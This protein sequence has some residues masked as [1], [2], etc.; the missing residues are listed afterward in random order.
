MNNCG[1]CINSDNCIKCVRLQLSNVNDKNEKYKKILHDIM[2]DID[3]ND[4]TTN[5]Y[6]SVL[7]EKNKNGEIIKKQNSQLGESY[8]I[9]D[10]GKNI[11][12]LSVKEKKVINAQDDLKN[13]EITTG[14]VQNGTYLYGMFGVVTRV[15][16]LFIGI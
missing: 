8:M 2:D 10:K 4:D 13:Y 6:E 3:L 15:V 11:D 9:M 7:V 1:E 12:E 16:G 14:Y 5:L